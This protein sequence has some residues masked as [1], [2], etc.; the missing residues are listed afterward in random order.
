[1]ATPADA[2]PTRLTLLISESTASVGPLE[3]IGGVDGEDL[4]SAGA[5]GASRPGRAGPAPSIEH[6]FVYGWDRRSCSFPDCDRTYYAKACAGRI[7]HSSCT[8]DR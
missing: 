5:H 4:G 1:M 7:T 8:I 6:T 3:R 2:V